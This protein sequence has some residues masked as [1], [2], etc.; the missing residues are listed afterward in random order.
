MGKFKKI[1]IIIGVLFLIGGI[2]FDTFFAGIPIQDATQEMLDT[3]DKNS[4][5]SNFLMISGI[6]I[7]LLGLIL[8]KEE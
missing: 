1:I 5:I 6:F 2:L 4:L 8:K 7:V 3:Y